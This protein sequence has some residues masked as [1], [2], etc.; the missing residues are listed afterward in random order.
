MCGNIFIYIFV[1]KAGGGLASIDAGLANNLPNVYNDIFQN[2]HR[3][4]CL[5]SGFW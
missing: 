1:L 4:D 2:T 3:E 5:V